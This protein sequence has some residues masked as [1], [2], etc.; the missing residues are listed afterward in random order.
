MV[1]VGVEFPDMEARRRRGRSA[2]GRGE[3]DLVCLRGFGS[4]GA[5]VADFDLVWLSTGSCFVFADRRG[6]GT[7]GLGFSFSCSVPSS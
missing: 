1:P 4:G 3:T 5:G 2:G 6:G 7:L